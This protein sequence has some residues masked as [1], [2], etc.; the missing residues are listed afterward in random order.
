MRQEF[1]RCFR[2]LELFEMEE[3]VCFA[4]FGACPSMGSANTMQMLWVR[5]WNSWLCR[6]HLQIPASDK[7]SKLRAEQ[8][9][10]ENVTWYSLP[11]PEGHQR[12]DHQ[13]CSGKCDHVDMAKLRIN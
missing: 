8:E 10:Q 3:S 4:S 11:G 13:R 9:Q 12:S 2:K 1:I 5:C 6:E 7:T